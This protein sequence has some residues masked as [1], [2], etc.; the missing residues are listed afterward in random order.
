MT[1]TGEHPRT[2]APSHSTASP[3]S[4]LWAQHG[5]LIREVFTFGCVGG[6]AF[7]VDIGTYSLLRFAGPQLL[8]SSPMKAYVISA[9]V[10]TVV[11]WLGNRLLTYRNR[12]R[13]AAWREFYSFAL[14]NILGMLITQ[15]CLFVS[16]YILQFKSYEADYVALYGVG[17]VLAT[18]FRF[19]AY[20]WWL[21]PDKKSA[22]APGN[23]A[24]HA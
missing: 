21:F 7:L 2:A 22:K 17:F 1:L 15:A 3:L 8:Y 6:T 23:N 19:A 24:T 18:L 4:S 5:K 9:A 20:R 10:A 12:S 13:M 16:H 11:A 14:V